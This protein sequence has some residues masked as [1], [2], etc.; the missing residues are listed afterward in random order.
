DAKI[1]AKGIGHSVTMMRMKRTN[2]IINPIRYARLILLLHNSTTSLS[3]N[4]YRRLLLSYDLACGC[5][6]FC[7]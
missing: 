2:L 6:L 4:N 3:L 7:K 5:F 1:K